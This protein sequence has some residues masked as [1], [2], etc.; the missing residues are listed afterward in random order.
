MQTHDSHTPSKAGWPF[1]V[2]TI[3]LLLAFAF[4]LKFALAAAPH[5]ADE[6]AARIA[7]RVKARQE[8]DADN[9]LK[10]E[11]YAWNDKA[12]GAVQIPIEAAKTM[13]IAQYQ[14]QQP[15]SAG[16]ITPATPAASAAP[17]TPAAPASP[18]PVTTTG[19]AAP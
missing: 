17:V 6:D 8:L 4:L 18:A 13:I 12:K 2:G 3:V 16:P 9:K 1:V 5:G 14:G 15:T 11:T 19:T 10:L 7:E